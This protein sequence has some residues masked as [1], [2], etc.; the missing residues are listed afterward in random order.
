MDRT[1]LFQSLIKSID[2][3]RDEIAVNIFYLPEGYFMSS[4]QTRK[5]AGVLTSFKCSK[6]RPE[7]LPIFNRFRTITLRFT[8]Q[9]ILLSENKRQKKRKDPNFRAYIGRTPFGYNRSNGELST[10]EAEQEAI[11]RIKHLKSNGSSLRE[12]AREMNERSIPTKNNGVWQANTVRK[13]LLW[14]EGQS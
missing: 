7:M 2:Y 13:I 1:Y 14:D 12:I 8:N 6:N 10:N 3:G 11:R 5:K 9:L 4:P